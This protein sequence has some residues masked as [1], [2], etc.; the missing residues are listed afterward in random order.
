MHDATAIAFQLV[1]A[2]VPLNL[3]CQ[4][5]EKGPVMMIA[6]GLQEGTVE[7]DTGWRLL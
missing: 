3:A 6:K 4:A 7:F 1:V 5:R 2:N